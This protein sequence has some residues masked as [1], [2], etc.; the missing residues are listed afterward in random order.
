M[1][2][3]VGG[4]PHFLL[5][6]AKIVDG[7]CL[8]VD[9]AQQSFVPNGL[10]GCG[11]HP[12]RP[13]KAKCRSNTR[14]TLSYSLNYG[15]HLSPELINEIRRAVETGNPVEGNEAGHA[16]FAALLRECRQH[17]CENVLGCKVVGRSYFFEQPF[18]GIVFF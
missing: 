1:V 13:P 18:L 17:V 10:S 12:S 9:H 15:R 16:E 3:G 11:I 4:Y 8:D 6:A 14:L 7:L 5:K 2:T